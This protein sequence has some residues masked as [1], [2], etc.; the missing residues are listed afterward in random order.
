MLPWVYHPGYSPPFPDNHRFPMAKFRHLA[1]DLL[2]RG[3]LSADDHVRAPLIGLADL[4]RVHCAHYVADWL[5]GH[6]SAATIKR[7]G[8]PWSQDIVQ[9]T[10]LETG[11]T[12]QAAELALQ[13][14]LAVN[15]AGG[16]HHAQ[17]DHPAGFCWINDLAITAAALRHHGR[18]QR[19]VI[20]DC[21]VHQGDGTAALLADWPGVWTVSLHA[22][23]NFPVRKAASHWDIPLPDGLDDAGYLAVLQPA[24][25]WLIQTLAPD[26]VLYDAGV[27]VHGDDRLGRL[28]LTDAGILARDR[29][30]LQQC[31]DAGVPVAAVI[32]GGYDPDPAVVARRH[33]LLIEAALTVHS[34]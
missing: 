20:L 14:G 32:G 17:R 31:R 18:V 2:T 30:V 19:V 26:L 5:S 13:H 6:L 10:R 11:G 7:S 24:L 29:T 21:D 25:D 8:L 1:A 33:A 34:V 15:L 28:A 27:D 4:Q 16:T 22:A 12:L 3:R 23:Q 9:R